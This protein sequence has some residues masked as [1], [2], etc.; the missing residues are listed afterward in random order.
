MDEG[1]RNS[2]IAAALILIGFGLFAY[3]LPTIM[4]AVGQYLNTWQKCALLGQWF[5]ISYA[6]ECRSRCICP[7]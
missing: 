1:N 2:A 7:S 4:I 5:S 6:A 3:F